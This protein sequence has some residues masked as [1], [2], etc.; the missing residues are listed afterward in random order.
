MLYRV[1][2]NCILLVDIDDGISINLNVWHTSRDLTFCN[3]VYE[4]SKSFELT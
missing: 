3:C 1:T 4:I 2:A